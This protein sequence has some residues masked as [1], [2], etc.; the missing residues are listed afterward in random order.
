[1]TKEELLSKKSHAMSM[2]DLRKFMEKFQYLDDNTPVL[3]ERV[4]DFYFEEKEFNGEKIRG[5]DT[6]KVEG[7][8]YLNSLEWNKKM[9]KE[10]ELRK[11]GKGEYD[12]TLI[13]E[14]TIIGEKEL[15]KM[16]EEFYRPHCISTD[17][18]I[19]YIHSHY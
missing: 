12:E 5:W 4:T 6:L 3:V 17:E 8:H 2:R 11:I 15:E 1:M 9:E 16:K 19:I 7:Y 18:E 10:I 14:D 13:P